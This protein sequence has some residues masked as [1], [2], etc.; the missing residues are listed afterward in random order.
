MSKVAR[1]DFLLLF[2][3]FAVNCFLVSRATAQDDYPLVVVAV[4]SVDRLLDRAVDVM[5]TS[6]NAATREDVVALL[7]MV[8]IDLEDATTSQWFD[9]TKPVGVMYF[10]DSALLMPA[11]APDAKKGEDDKESAA[12]AYSG[13]F[14]AVSEI[15]LS[16]KRF[17]AYF[18]VKDYQQFLALAKLT[19]VEGKANCFRNDEG[20]DEYLRRFGNYVILGDDGDTVD[21]CP[22][23]REIGKSVLGKNDVAV[24]L[25]LKGL[26]PLFRSLG[27][28]GIKSVYDAGL[29]RRDDEQE[30][31]Y[32]L[33]RALG[34]ISRELLDLAMTQVDEV[35][36]GIRIEAGVR[37]ILDLEVNGTAEGKLAKFAT[38][39]TPKKSAF[40]ALWNADYNHS[41]GISLA[42]PQ[43][44]TRPLAA[45]IQNYVATATDPDQ[46]KELKEN[47]SMINLG[48]R[49]LESNK[50]ELLCTG[51][52]DGD[53]NVALYGLK[54]PTNRD[55]PQQFE[56]W[57][58]RVMNDDE[59][60]LTTTAVEGWPVHHIR[61][62]PFLGD[63]MQMMVS[64]FSGNGSVA[65]EGQCDSWLMATPDA[66][67]ICSRAGWSDDAIPTMLHRAI[68][69]K[70]LVARDAGNRRAVAPFR[71]SLHPRLWKSLNF[72]PDE[73]DATIDRKPDPE[74]E[75]NRREQENR[76][77]LFD[78]HPDEIL[79]E[80]LPTA[81]GL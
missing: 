34:D 19:P 21:H 46:V 32:L 26:P 20:V 16:P 9:L 24:S 78:A 55:F 40:D 66:I 13:L 25:Q 1:C 74:H 44:H 50:F 22:D 36:L 70:T 41:L 23:P 35:T 72:E 27:A 79:V 81:R 64:Q 45:A 15:G 30:R 65:A 18:P 7:K 67:W 56:E 54:L 77:Q 59:K 3:A 11:A 17:V 69:F 48:C 10:F 80:L 63:I 73:S 29:Q 42:L 75:R 5:Q 2:A 4:A 53:A 33:R 71:M 8:E 6:G 52:R 38:E 68:D 49:I 61:T 58:R 51:E 37:S 76:Q 43:R 60:S 14:G 31:N 57:M 28:E 39:I 62:M 12:E 47:A